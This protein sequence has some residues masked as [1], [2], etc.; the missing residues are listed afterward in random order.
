MISILRFLALMGVFFI[1]WF[2][3]YVFIVIWF[4]ELGDKDV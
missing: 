1:V 2:V 4:E 3:V